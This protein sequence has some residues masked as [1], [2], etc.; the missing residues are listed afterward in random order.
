MTATPAPIDQAALRAQLDAGLAA[1]DD[2]GI[3]AALPDAARNRLIAYLAL[4]TRWNQAF[5]LTAVRDPEAMVPRHLLDSLAVLP[6]VADGP[7]LDLGTGA[8]LPGIPLAL[9]RPALAFTLLDG[10]GKK[11]RFVRQAVAELGLGNCTAVQARAR[12]Y[13]PPAKFA[14]IVARAV[15]PL[16][17]LCAECTHLAAPGARLLALKGRRPADELAALPAHAAVAVHRLGVPGADG[18][19]HLIVVP[20]DP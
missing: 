13:R 17:G 19:R 14:T 18:A 8:G 1:L 4:L 5:N 7:V 6:W 15:A 12:T 10:N 11:V 20:L 9:A 16:A 3:G 2:P